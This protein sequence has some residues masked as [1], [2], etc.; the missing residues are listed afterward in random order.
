MKPA[1]IKAFNSVPRFGH[2]SDITLI[3]D[4][5]GVNFSAL[6]DYFEGTLFVAGFC[7]AVFII[8]VL[9]LLVLKCFG[10]KAGIAAGHPFMDSGGNTK[11]PMRF[12]IFMLISSLLVAISGVVFLVRGARSVG[13]AYDD[14]R[15]G[16]N[17]LTN[18]A[19][20]IVNATDEVIGFGE[21]TVALRDNIVVELE[22]KVCT[23]DGSGGVADQFDQA[24]TS[25]VN[26]LTAL[27]DF[28]KNELTDIRNT[29]AMEFNSVSNDLYS[30]SE[31]G[32]SYSQPSYIAGPVI[33]FGLLLTLGTYLAWKG[34]FIKP[35]FAIQTWLILPIFSIIVVVIA[36]VLAVT[37]TV[38]VAN[39]DVCLGGES[40]SPEGFMELVIQ[41]AGF[42]GDT[43]EAS[44][45][46]IVN[47]SPLTLS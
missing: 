43:L 20:L 25:V 32:E 1:P 31:T 41:K 12:R 37:G 19:E 33:G 9:A 23:A 26:I 38:L 11:R 40:K 47:V 42:T 34:P 13:N 17:G 39:S 21:D 16:S 22:Q 4:E 14:I 29:F 7:L 15:D 46:Y 44:N 3:Y 10:K 30:A 28:S 2:S 8:W 6:R 18:I 27:Q 24:A 5:N 45:Y 36:I 35:Y